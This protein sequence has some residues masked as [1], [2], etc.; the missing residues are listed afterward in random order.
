MAEAMIKGIFNAD[1]ASP[2]DIL[3]GEPIEQ[4]RDYL[5]RTY[6]LSAKLSNKSVIDSSDIVVLAVKP[7]NLPE[8]MEDISD[9][10]TTT[11]VVLSIIAGVP[12]GTLT[13]ELGHA[14]VIRAMPNTPG[15]IGSGM[16]VWTSS[17]EVPDT[18]IQISRD[19]LRTLGEELHVPDEKMVDMATAVSASGPAYVFL[20]I[21]AMIDASVYLG[22][23][24]N[25]ARKL[26]L[27]TVSG[28]THLVQETDKHPAVLRDLVTS[29]GGTT[30]EALLVLENSGFRASI[31]KAISSAFD[32][33]IALGGPPQ[34]K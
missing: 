12:I 24:R 14:A 20:F 31:M 32:K 29:P 22:M 7:Q 6:G 27:Q 19:I 8:S 15:Q 16:T 30:A 25:I 17:N 1:I 5:T 2:N 23:P 21:E 34:Q 33:S 10:L 13:T 11:Q 28:S 26:V 4:R 18:G 3:V 9:S